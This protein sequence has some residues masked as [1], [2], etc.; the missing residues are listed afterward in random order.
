[1]KSGV[2]GAPLG[3]VTSPFLKKMSALRGPRSDLCVVVVT[4]WQCLDMISFFSTQK[5]RIGS[6]TNSNGDLCSCAATRPEK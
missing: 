4:M 3:P 2:E 5:E 1:M 6:E